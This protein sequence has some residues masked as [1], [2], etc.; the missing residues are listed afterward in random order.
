MSEYNI[1]R[2]IHILED[3]EDYNFPFER[4]KH[5]LGA[6]SYEK[7]FGKDDPSLEKKPMTKAEKRKAKKAEQQKKEEEK[8]EEEPMIEEVTD[9]QAD[10]IQSE[11]K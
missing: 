2:K 1:W 7:Q 5:I 8:K 3:L 10:Q 4:L 9:E 11:Q 6:A